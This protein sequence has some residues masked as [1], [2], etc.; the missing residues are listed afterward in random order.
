MFLGGGL[1]FLA[2]DLSKWDNQIPIL[3]PVRNFPKC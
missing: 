2:H 1:G 3:Y